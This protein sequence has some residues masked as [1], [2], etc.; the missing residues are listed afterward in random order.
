MKK[1]SNLENGLIDSLSIIFRRVVEKM[2]SKKSGMEMWLGN[3][4]KG[5]ERSRE[6][7]VALKAGL[8]KCEEK[9]VKMEEM[10][11]K[12]VGFKKVEV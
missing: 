5:I 6:R 2:E 4:A 3:L 10:F 8:Q 11:K 12:A 7:R 9:I 1:L